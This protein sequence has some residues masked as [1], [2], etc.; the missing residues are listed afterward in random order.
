MKKYFTII[1]IGKTKFKCSAVKTFA[2]LKN[3]A[4]F[5]EISFE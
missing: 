1:N 3:I 5:N 4:V 2:C